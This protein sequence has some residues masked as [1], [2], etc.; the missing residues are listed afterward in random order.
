MTSTQYS[1]IME[2]IHPIMEDAG[3]IHQ[4]M[5]GARLWMDYYPSESDSMQALELVRMVHG[6]LTVNLARAEEL[7]LALERSRNL[8]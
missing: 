3:S 5:H 4:L 1:E 7:I 2:L 8:L 6:L